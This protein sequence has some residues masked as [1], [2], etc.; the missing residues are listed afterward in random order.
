LTGSETNQMEYYGMISD[1][2]S[3]YE[4][5]IRQL[6]DIVLSFDKSGVEY[7]FNWLGGFELDEE[8]QANIKFVEAQT[9]AIRAQWNTRNEI[10][11]IENPEASDL[12]EGQGGDEVLGM[13]VPFGG[14]DDDGEDSLEK[15]SEGAS[16]KVTEL[17]KKHEHSASSQSSA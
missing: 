16:Y 4:P 3:Q 8:K 10:R 11:K 7:T 5:G 13:A 17:H 2:Q 14:D 1:E 12:P 15:L 9:L 6:V